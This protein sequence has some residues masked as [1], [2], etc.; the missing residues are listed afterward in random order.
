MNA[1]TSLRGKRVRIY[2]DCITRTD[3]EAEALIVQV[4]RIDNEDPEYC[5]FVRFAHDDGGPYFRTF[6]KQD[7]I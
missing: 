7:L 6:G 2:Q 1:K 5:G 3:Y 4:E